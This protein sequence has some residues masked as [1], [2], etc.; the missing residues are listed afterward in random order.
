MGVS[1][2]ELRRRVLMAQPH[3]ERK[4]GGIVSFSTHVPQ[5]L[6]VSVPLS[7]VQA[8]TGDPYPPGGGKNK[9]KV[10]ATTQTL[11]GITFTVNDDGTVVANGTATGNAFLVLG[12][13]DFLRDS[14]TKTYIINGCPPGGSGS[15]YNVDVQGASG[16]DTGA[17]V[18]VSYSNPEFNTS[19]RIRIYNG[20]TVN[21]LVFKPMIR[22]ASESDATFAPYS[23]I[24]P[25]SG[26]T[27][28]AVCRAGEN[29]LDLSILRQGTFDGIANQNN[30]SFDEFLPIKGGLQY[31]WSTTIPNI[32]GR[33]VRF[34][35]ATK[36]MISGNS[37]YG[38]GAKKFTAPEN[39][40]YFKAMWYRSGGLPVADVT[41][42]QI[43]PGATAHDFA[44]YSG[45]SFPFEFPAY[46]RNL[47]EGV[48]IE[49]GYYAADGAPTSSANLRRTADY[50]PVNA[51]DA[52]KIVLLP[53][54]SSSRIRV[55]EYDA[56]K[57]WIRQVYVSNMLPADKEFT[58]EWT[59]SDDAKYIR[60][61][62]P[63]YDSISAYYISNTVYGGR[64]EPAAGRV[65]VDRALVDLGTLTWVSDPNRLTVKYTRSLSGSI[66][67][68]YPWADAICSEYAL[69]KNGPD[70]IRSGQFSTTNAYGAGYVLFKDDAFSGMTVGEVKEYLSGVQLVYEL[71]EPLIV[72]L[73]PAEIRALMGE[74][75]VFADTGDVDVEFWT[76]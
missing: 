23:N 21:N 24:R 1:A 4:T 63:K 49:N 56:N 52:C 39:A 74:N 36:T 11:N 38:A 29:L 15:T 19:V 26:H 30:V 28:A 64:L 20:A 41:E 51:G 58:A 70:A 5:V 37:L 69:N 9:L 59:I 68:K 76:N 2:L 65:V 44:P 66:F 50:I 10:T 27:G 8:G 7:P 72:P 62:V 57:D 67:K 3:K 14:P 6:G 16:A 71:A 13:A 48:T 53:N 54:V 73:T 47:L 31:V 25:I 22:L 75:N 33:Y 43:E 60:F 55:H 45:E 12:T 34:Y 46:E 61:S 32:S 35:D 40:L 42:D 18:L 17:G